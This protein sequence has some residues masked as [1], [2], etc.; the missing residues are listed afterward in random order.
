MRVAIG[1]LGGLFTAELVTIVG[2]AGPGVLAHVLL[3]V[4][5]AML[6]LRMGSTPTHRLLLSL[7]MLPL[8]RIVSLAVPAA[9]IPIQYWYLRSGWQASKACSSC[10]G[11]ST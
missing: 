9:I 7:G 5:V 8:V 6:S 10:F 11:G 4:A 3:L 2:G 1:L